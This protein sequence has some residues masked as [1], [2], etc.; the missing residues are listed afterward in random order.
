MTGRVA[1]FLDHKTNEVGQ[2]GGGERGEVGGEE[3]LGSERLERS[4]SVQGGVDFLRQLCQFRCKSEAD[5]W[6]LGADRRVET[7][8][9]QSAST[10]DSCPL[11]GRTH[12]EQS[13]SLDG[14]Q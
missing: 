2:G 11:T 12:T 14:N 10:Q 1:E 8:E 6:Q 13:T 4:T 5:G 7:E 9:A 3:C